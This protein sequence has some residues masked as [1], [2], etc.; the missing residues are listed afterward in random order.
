MFNLH[1]CLQLGHVSVDS[2][3]HGDIAFR[4][5]KHGM[6]MSA[7]YQLCRHLDSVGCLAVC[8]EIFTWFVCLL[9]QAL[10]RDG[11]RE[12]GRALLEMW[13]DQVLDPRT[14]SDNLGMRAE[15]MKVLGCCRVVGAICQSGVKRLLMSAIG[16]HLLVA[17]DRCD[18]SCACLVPDV[19]VLMH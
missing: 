2:L 6:V 17:C 13:V 12:A 19:F 1:H 14:S 16:I 9:W 7:E 8:I 5:L 4:C 3:S 11:R 18:Q 10:V 15:A